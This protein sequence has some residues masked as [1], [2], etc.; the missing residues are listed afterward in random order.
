MFHSVQQLTSSPRLPNPALQAYAAAATTAQQLLV[1]VL[2]VLAPR[3]FARLRPLLYA[4][5]ATFPTSSP[6]ASTGLSAVSCSIP[7]SPAFWLSQLLASGVPW[8]VAHAV[9]FP[10]TVSQS[11]LVHGVSHCRHC[12][13]S[14]RPARA[15]PPGVS[16]GLPAYWAAAPLPQQG[17][18][19][20]YKAHE[21]SQP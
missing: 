9:L 3:K 13:R 20:K 1:W 18:P 11:L 5:S 2:A 17:A 4:L 10:L 12:R 14:A 7:G 6:L 19:Y 8:L 15:A 21:H 16:L